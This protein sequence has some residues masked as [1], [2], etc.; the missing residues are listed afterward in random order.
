MGTLTPY[1]PHVQGE[2]VWPSDV[3]VSD[4][5]KDFISKMLVMAPSKRATAA[6]VCCPGSAPKWCACFR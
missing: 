4:E 1:S 3:K 2:Y 5:A 6:E